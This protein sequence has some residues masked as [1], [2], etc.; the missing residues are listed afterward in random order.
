MLK[1][2][3]YRCWGYPAEGFPEFHKVAYVIMGNKCYFSGLERGTS[4]INAAEDVIASIA[5]QEGVDFSDLRYFDIQT[6]MSYR[7]LPGEYEVNEL[8]YEVCREATEQE[9]I[10]QIEERFGCKVVQSHGS[11]PQTVEECN[12]VPSVTAWGKALLPADVLALFK[13]HIGIDLKAT[14]KEV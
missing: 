12:I 9:Q 8:E 4:T 1:K 6:R 14:Y 11:G 7:K 2:A 10:E 5:K 13:E 3:K